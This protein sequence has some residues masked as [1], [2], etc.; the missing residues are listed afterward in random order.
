MDNLE[1]IYR[2]VAEE[3]GLS[4]NLVKEIAEAQFD[5]VVK[6]IT[7][8]ELNDVRLQYW[9]KFSVKPERLKHLDRHPTEFKKRIK[10]KLDGTIEHI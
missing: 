10:D 9:G 2:D 7:A 6:T 4:K 8:G 3:L 1:K 5:L